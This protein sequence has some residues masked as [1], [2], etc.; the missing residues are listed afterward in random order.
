MKGEIFAEKEHMKGMGDNEKSLFLQNLTETDLFQTIFKCSFAVQLEDYQ[1]KY[2]DSA[3]E[4]EQ[5]KSKSRFN[6]H[7][8]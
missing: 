2:N 6:T 7:A 3:K 8:A 5:H 1:N 4:A